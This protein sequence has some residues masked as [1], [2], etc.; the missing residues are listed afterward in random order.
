MLLSKN[1]KLTIIT[2]KI[3]T[4]SSENITLVEIPK[5]IFPVLISF[6]RLLA[7]LIATLKN[8]K[9]FD[10]VFTRIF[11]I[12]F[13]ISAIIAK[14]F[15]KKKLVVWIPGSFM[16]KQRKIMFHRNIIKTALSVADIIC[17]PSEQVVIDIEKNLGQIDRSKVKIFDESPNISIFK[18][19]VKTSLNNNICSISRIVPLK[20]IEKIIYSLPL[21]IKEIP[22]VKFIHVGPIQDKKYF[23]SLKDLITS[24]RC[25]KSIE[26]WGP[27]AHD[28]L[29]NVYNSSKIFVLMT[30]SEGQ[31]LVTKEAMSCGK[32]VIVTPVGAIPDYVKDGI[33]GFIL[34]NYDSKKLAE[35]IIRLL[36]DE[37]LREKIGAAARESM[38]DESS[39]NSFARELTN[40][41]N[42]LSTN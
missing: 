33:N 37:K 21:V 23:E 17:A 25:E 41:F 40:I 16:T 6:Q 32:P 8:K 19:I 27:I 18:P 4:V 28:K 24:L 39:K 15:F 35:I 38:E 5:I 3:G 14:K 26:F 9:K 10:I 29:V 1:V 12:H 34:N 20:A 13:L 7:Y 36:K 2:E 11:R 42:E 30:K 22:D 31:S